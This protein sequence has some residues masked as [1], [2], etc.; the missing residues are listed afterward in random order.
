[1]VPLSTTFC[2]D[3]AD[4]VIRAA[5][6]LD[7][8]V[9]KCILSLVSP[10][11][12]E[13]LTGSPQ[14]PTDAP[15]ILPH[16]DVQ[17]SPKTWENILRT[18]Y[19]MS[20]PTI[21]DL[22]DLESVLLVAREYQIQS[23]IDIHQKGLENW[24]FIQRDPLRLYAIACMLG[25]E[26]QAKYVARNAELLAITRRSDVS[27]LEG[28]TVDSYHNLVSFL[29]ERDNEWDQ[30]LGEARISLDPNCDC[31]TQWKE[32]LYNKVKKNLKRP[33]LRTEEIYLK[34]LEDRWRYP[35]PAC[36]S[37]I[38]CSFPSLEIKTFI[39]RMMKEREKVCDKL[40]YEKR[41]VK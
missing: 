34:A 1:M 41:Y 27:D 17:D 18:I 32:S 38:K 35:Q 14:S 39:E 20:N 33:Y 24:A 29:A 28:L 16:L 10:L 30:T 19:P 2:A 9:H 4:M 7:F 22:D 15:G 5:G 8:R 13:V 40:V 23:I 12:E 31:N 36:T 6:K 11:F 3:D 26:D 21:D 37:V 25:F